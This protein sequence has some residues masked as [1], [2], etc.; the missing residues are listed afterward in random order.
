MKS[1]IVNQPGEEEVYIECTATLYELPFKQCQ[2]FI[3]EVDTG[4]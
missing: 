3:T 2:V 4:G 1:V